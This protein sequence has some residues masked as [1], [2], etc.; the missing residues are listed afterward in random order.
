[1]WVWPERSVWPLSV[2]AQSLKFQAQFP[3]SF[4]TT[5]FG[6]ESRGQPWGLDLGNG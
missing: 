6:D 3:F 1:M 4:G 2:V 5:S